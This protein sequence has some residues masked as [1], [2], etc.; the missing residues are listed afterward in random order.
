VARRPR[1]HLEHL[2]ISAVL[3]ALAGFAP[4]QAAIVDD[5]GTLDAAGFLAAVQAERA[6]LAGHGR[7]ALLADN[8]RGWA[9][10]DLALLAGG[11][12]NVPLPHHFGDAQ[13]AHAITSAGVTAALTD[14]PEG[15]VRL[16]LGFAA[17]GQSP[18]TGLTLLVRAP[19][20]PP[21]PLPPG[22]VK[23]TYT[24][25]STAEPK[26]VCLTRAALEAVATS[27]AGVA[28]PLGIRRHLAVL[29]LA[30]LLENV[31]GLYAAW[32][33]G[34]ACQL[35][36][37]T[38]RAIARGTLT[39]ALLLDE[40]AKVAPESV[41][42]VPELL[43]IL[44]L[45][46]EAGWQ[47]PAGAKFFAVGGARVSPELLARARA[48]GVP[49]WEGYGL[50]ECASVVCLNAPGAER[51]GTVGRPLPHAR[52]HVDARGEIHVAGALM[53]G[54]VGEAPRAGEW[55]ATGD[56]GAV[57]A[58]GFVAVQGR[59]K[60]LFINSYGRNLS[61]EWI[62]SELGQEPAIGQVVAVG[63]ARPDVAALITPAHPGVTA[64][65]IADSVARANAR[66]PG[67]ARVARYHL[68][69]E[70]MTVANGLLTGNGRPRRERILERYA[71][72]IDRLY[73]EPRHA[74]Q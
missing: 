37:A 72:T 26:G 67:Y 66:L 49:A 62:E 69:A 52:V 31:A 15:I 65:A 46:A 13:L 27:V 56:L 60:N 34:A 23:V 9:V 5:R 41:I 6:W 28:G 54:Y 19:D 50:S 68:V 7:V 38:A 18:H 43:R 58:D 39:P 12:V 29:P 53:A 47:P 59:A 22:T 16:G 2:T 1:P 24:S 71:Q 48:A 8:G 70:R 42:L 33:A 4:G 36:S 14:V 3:E 32:F 35:P 10:T 11:K 74:V 51:A 55:L 20:G 57:D 64:A 45:G 21:P 25:G 17:A 61:P 30:T 63:E 40:V 73:G 44:A